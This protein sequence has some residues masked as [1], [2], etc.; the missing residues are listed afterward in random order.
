MQLQV[1]KNRDKEYVRIVESFRDPETKKPKLR[2]I[3]T[4]GN[5]EKLLSEDP[6]ALEALQAKVDRMNADQQTVTSAAMQRHLQSFI[7]AES[8]TSEHAGAPLLNYGFEVYQK[9]WDAL[10]LDYFFQYRQKQH[11]NIQF[12]TKVS[13]A[14]MTYA[15]YSTPIPSG[16]HSKAKPDSPN[17]LIA[18][19]RICIVHYHFSLH[20]KNI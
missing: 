17:R 7:D 1:Y 18:S 13:T 6:N 4:F 9:L 10:N 16:R 20:R 19:N 12:P 15:R 5:K 2:V 3:E 8:L 14:L 11:S